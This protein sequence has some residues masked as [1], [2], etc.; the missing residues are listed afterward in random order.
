MRG[1]R[2]TPCFALILFA[3]SASAAPFRWTVG[4]DVAAPQ[5]NSADAE[6]GVVH[7]GKNLRVQIALWPNW[8]RFSGKDFDHLTP[9][10]DAQ[11]DDSFDQPHGDDAYWTTGI[12]N[13]AVGKFYAIVHVEYDY[14]KPRRAFLW[15][16]RI[17]LAT[18]TDLGAHWNYEGDIL[19]T[20]PARRGK[21]SAQFFD[22]GCGDT[23]LFP[24]RRSG[25]FYI[26]YMTAWVK[27]G[28]G[29]RI[30][31]AM[32]VARSPMSKG[33]AAGSWKKWNGNGWTEPGLGGAET[34]VFR[35]AD[36]AS[37]HFNSYLGAFV[38]LGR[39]SDARCWI[40]T[41][42]SL[43]AE[44]WT[45]RD[46]AFPQRFYWYN[47][48]VDSATNECCEIGQTFRVYSSQAA[49]AGVGSKFMEVKFLE[50]QARSK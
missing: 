12:W 1:S 17:G 5:F 15:R 3:A 13:D 22:F 4:G 9:L 34:P 40:A 25:F 6:P 16:R 31:Q 48:A 28:S 46:Y 20:N 27:T 19:R 38:A 21:P 33:M 24:D 49:T 10:P 8:R 43:A 2:F 45:R 44:R 26:F 39:D 7:D 47:W 37:V 35:G 18:S 11:R 42:P 29:E 30:A 36:S 14:A 23:Y 50:S 41:C 32:N